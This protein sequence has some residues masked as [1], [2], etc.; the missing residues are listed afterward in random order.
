MKNKNEKDIVLEEVIK[1]Y[2]D[3]LES[4]KNTYDRREEFKTFILDFISSKP[5][6]EIG[7]IMVVGHS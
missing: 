6:E 5:I 3:R 1:T 4:A 7:Q 2:P